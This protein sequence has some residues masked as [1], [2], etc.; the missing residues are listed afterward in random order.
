[1]SGPNESDTGSTSGEGG[2]AADRPFAQWGGSASPVFA[3][4]RWSLV[5]A[6]GDLSDPARGAALEQ[7]CKVYWYP[8]YGFTRRQGFDPHQS[9]D[10]VQSFF[11]RLLE[12]N[13]LAGLT[14]DRARFRSFLLTALS[15]FLISE[16]ERAGAL[17][18]GG[19]LVFV[20]MDDAAVEE[21]YL[22]ETRSG[23]PL[24]PARAFE[25]QWAV[26]LLESAM[27]ALAAEQ[28]AEGKGRAWRA[29]K[30][31]LSREPEPGE[32]ATVAAGLD[33]Q[34][35]ALGV[36]VHRL[37]QRYRERV[38]EAVAATVESPMDVDDEMRHL[39]EALS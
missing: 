36:A 22:A 35:G 18:R 14:P 7:F 31:F 26:A 25:R 16:R 5:L 15:R 34:P 21:R 4:T 38:R 28:E 32:Y 6:A 12:R 11:L 27:A 17:K 20:P 8:L 19:G 1:M 13:D 23:Q 9:Q 2:R 33:M 10:L 39:L 29:M 3:T 37:R 30:V 24:T